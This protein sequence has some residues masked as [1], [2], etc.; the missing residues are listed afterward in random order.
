MRRRFS[1]K[2]I[3]GRSCRQ[4]CLLLLL[5]ALLAGVYPGWL[6][7]SGNFHPIPGGHAY[8]SGQLSPG[9]LADVLQTHHIRSVV[10]LRGANPGKPWYETELALCQQAGVA[11]FDFE[12]GSSRM[13]S[14]DDL[15]RLAAILRTAPKPVLLHC[16]GGADRTGLAAALFRLNVEGDPPPAAAEELTWVYGH[17]P[18]LWWSKTSA[19]DESFWQYARN[20]PGANSVPDAPLNAW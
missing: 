17:I 15:E 3:C 10:N 19:M 1:L 11:H 18:C 9:R 5:L 8:R 2:A 16:N 4:R 12:L 14:A 7:V 13:A 6:M 20:H